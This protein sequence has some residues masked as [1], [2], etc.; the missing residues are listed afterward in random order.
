MAGKEGKIKDIL[1]FP[2]SEEEWEPAMELCWKTFLK[3]E[4]PV[5]SEEGVKNFLS[6]ISGDQLHQMFLNGDYKIWVAKS[7][8]E[9]IGVGSLRAASHISLLFVAE[10]YQHMGVGRRL[11][12][13]MQDSLPR[14]NGCKLTV[15]SSPYGEGFYHKLGFMDSDKEQKTDGIIY[16]P[17]VL[18]ER[19]QR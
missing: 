18:L 19:L 16:T 6:F 17:M 2:A 14:R 9:I 5:Y 15:N 11:V 12:K 8:G 4:A 7:G 1:I 3:F 13:R 10:E